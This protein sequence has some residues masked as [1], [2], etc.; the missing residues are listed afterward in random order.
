MKDVKK[1]LLILY[2]FVQLYTAS[3][4]AT[5]FAKAYIFTVNTTKV[6]TEVELNF[7]SLALDSNVIAKDLAYPPFTSPKFQ[8]LCEGL[9][10][11]NIDGRPHTYL[12]IG[13]STEDDIVFKLNGLDTN[14]EKYVLNST[15]WDTINI[16]AMKFQWK[17]IF[18]L[19]SLLRRHDG[20]WDPI[21]AIEFMRYTASKG[22]LVNYELGNE[23]DL[24][25]GHRNISLHPDQLARDFGT[26]KVVIE[27]ESSGA[28]MIFGP[29]VATLHRDEYF[30]KFV[31]NIEED[32]LNAVTFHFYYGASKNATLHNFTDPAYLDI[33][34]QKA[35]DAKKIVASSPTTKDIPIWVGETGSTYGG[36]AH[37][38]SDRFAAGFLWLDKLGLAA[39]LNISVIIRQTL[40]GGQYALVDKDL[41]PT[42]DYWISVLYKQ[43]V[44]Y[45][46][47]NVTNSL[48]ANRTVRVYAHCVNTYG[49]H[50]YEKGAITMFAINLNAT[51]DAYIN[52]TGSLK[53]L[54]ASQ[55]LLQAADGDV[56]S[57][58]VML[59]G[60]VLEMVGNKLPTLK[61]VSVK[62]PYYLPPLTF[63]EKLCNV[64]TKTY[65]RAQIRSVRTRS[66]FITSKFHG[67]KAF[68]CF[69]RQT[70]L[71]SWRG[72]FLKTRKVCCLVTIMQDY[73]IPCNRSD[74][75]LNE[76][77]RTT[78]MRR[79]QGE[80]WEDFLGN[81]IPRGI[82]IPR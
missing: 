60:V 49:D 78:D 58:D 44:G 13:G 16:F 75:I 1:L 15:E 66:D 47:L 67:P 74:W 3:A 6:V 68:C 42:P 70:Y 51:E 35:N 65:F 57:K 31:T 33:F 79:W 7:L 19:N 5:H 18:G 26:L 20:S 81:G 22:Y 61:S 62:Q 36:G 45:R 25:L 46:V 43:L 4:N 80:I 39:R 27:E 41:N 48:Q 77:G 30:K 50:K 55:Y 37:N 59:N 76:E 32:I 82:G 8:A 34:M 40:M 73:P 17:L 21:N 12:R 56:T 38:L 52:L 9:A 24:Y 69:L 28:P 72:R 14:S 11:I 23:P 53:G 71:T 63:F 64:C 2:F 54:G 10:K 29:D